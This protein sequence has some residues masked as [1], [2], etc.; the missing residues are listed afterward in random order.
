MDEA[1][2]LQPTFAQAYTYDPLNR[3]ETAAESGTW[4]QSYEYDQYGNRCVTLASYIQAAALTPQS[5]AAFGAVNNR[6]L[7]AGYDSAVSDHRRT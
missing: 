4:A 6:L 5:L 7:N 1:L 2:K 3:L